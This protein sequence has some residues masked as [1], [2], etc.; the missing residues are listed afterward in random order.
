MAGATTVV[1]ADGEVTTKPMGTVYFNLKLPTS[2]QYGS[3]EYGI[4]LPYEFGDSI[5]ETEANAREATALAKKIVHEN[6]GADYDVSYDF[7]YEEVKSRLLQAFPGAEIVPFPE[8]ET[9]PR[10]SPPGSWP[11]RVKVLKPLNDDH[12][13]WLDAQWQKLVDDGKVDKTHNEVWD[14]RKFLPQHGGNGN[15]NAPWY[16]VSKGGKAGIWPPKETA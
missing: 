13:D 7:G 2:V 4:Y 12:P 16:R 10:V 9:G 8:K 11:R 15:P 6:M 14:N 3:S 5:E 1:N